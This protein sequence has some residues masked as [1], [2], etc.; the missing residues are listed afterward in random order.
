MLK[1]LDNVKLDLQKLRAQLMETTP[2]K[3]RATASKLLQA[4][5][6][7]FHQLCEGYYSGT[8]ARGKYEKHE[9]AYNPD[10][11]MTTLKQD[12][13][14]YFKRVENQVEVFA[15][16]QEDIGRAGKTHL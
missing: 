5:I 7:R 11:F 14:R 1:A 12:Y 13:E 6:K 16:F 10:N 9:R 4:I 8:L 3:L 2:N 15:Q